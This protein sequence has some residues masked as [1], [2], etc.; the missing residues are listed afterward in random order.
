STL[1]LGGALSDGAGVFTLTKVGAGTLVLGNAANTYDGG[2]FVN[3]GTLSTSS[4]AGLGAASSQVTLNNGG[5]LVITSNT[6][7]GRTFNLNTGSLQVAAGA[8]LT[9]VSATVNGGFLRGPGAHAIG[10]NSTFSGVTALSGNTITQSFPTTLS[11]FTNSGSFISN[12]LL[13]WDGGYNTSAGTLTINDAFNITAF[14][15]TGI[16][17]VNNG[18]LLSNTA[19]NFVSGG[20]SRI[21]VNPSGQI[22][23]NS[24]AMDLNGALLINNGTITGATNVNYGSL[25]KGSGVYGAVN[26]LDGGKF[27]PGNSPGF[28][29]TGSVSWNPGGNYTVEMSDALGAPGTGWDL[30]NIAG[31]LLTNASTDPS[32]RFTISLA[33]LAGNSPG[34][35]ANF[36]NTR[37]YSWLI[38]RADDG[39]LGFDPAQ[40][41]LDVSG[42][43]NNLGGGHF[44]LESSST[45][46]YV[47]FAAVPEPAAI[48]LFVVAALW[49][50]RR[51]R[52]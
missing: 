19:N 48:G 17:N 43:R 30:W 33:S 44:A 3:G 20:G 27:S 26:V 22:N 47:R 25:A 11:N 40:L 2:T 15:N 24:T 34:F 42:F 50:A 29:T 18:G 41:A 51:R 1:T 45:D 49:S 37:D 16:V 36:D 8:T 28:V 5:K 7:S 39:I 46:L 9:Y 6:T 4:D 35:A 12:A 10:A 23:L 52:F 38:L 21:T 14:E 13:T 32:G 31:D